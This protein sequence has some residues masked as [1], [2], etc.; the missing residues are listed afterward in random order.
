MKLFAAFI[1]FYLRILSGG[2]GMEMGFEEL[3]PPLPVFYCRMDNLSQPT[4]L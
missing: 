4:I 2:K 3:T 1:W